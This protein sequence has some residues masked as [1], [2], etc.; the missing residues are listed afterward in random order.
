MRVFYGFDALPA[1]RNPVVTV[2]SYDGVHQGHRKLLSTIAE[3]AAKRNG[4]SVVVTFSPHPR[5]VLAGGGAV[6][7]LNTLD[8]KIYLLERVGIDNLIVAPFT[9][10]FSQL[11]SEEFVSG[12]L[13]DK[14]GVST[15]VVGYNHHFGHNKGGDFHS[16]ERLG[17]R[18]GFDI[19]MQ[20]RHDVDRDKVSSTVI[21]QL[22]RRGE[23]SQAARYLG[24][25]Y[26][27]IG[28]PTPEGRFEA[29]DPAK[30]LPP[31]G[32]YSVTVCGQTP[33]RRRLTVGEHGE[34]R[35]QPPLPP[36][37][38]VKYTVCFI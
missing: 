11:S 23:V 38:G 4:E 31:A 32:E 16:L 14:V 33:P 24:S 1:L 21:R 15:L 22:I 2:G 10:Q 9:P 18:Y 17:G 37:C 35:L 26:M 7:L 12:Y 6:E 5:Q 30:L 27:V 8:E 29:G 34:M 20:P 19:Y 25:P 28:S 13:V 36:E 3:I